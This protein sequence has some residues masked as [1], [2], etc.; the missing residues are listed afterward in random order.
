MIV[1]KRDSASSVEIWGSGNPKRE[2]MHVD[3]LA[4]AC[5]FLMQ[6]YDEAGWINVGVGEDVSILELAEIIRDVVGFKGELVFD[7]SKPDGTPRK[8]MD[9]TRIHALGW[10]ASIQLRAG[11]EKVYHEIQSLPF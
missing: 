2:F 1:A 6:Q 10:K 4:D 9:S 11:I 7:T 8:L 5:H 3:D